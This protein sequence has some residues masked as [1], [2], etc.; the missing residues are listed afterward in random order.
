MT[1]RLRLRLA[2]VALLHGSV[3]GCSVSCGTEARLL[4]QNAAPRFEVIS[5]KSVSSAP[6]GPGPQAPDL[7][8]LPF[9]TALN[10][11]SIAYGLPVYRVIGGPSWITSDRFQVL[12]KASSSPARGQIRVLVRKLIEERFRFSG[13]LESRELPAYDLVMARSDRR[14]GPNL[15][16]APVDC[17]PYLIGERPENEGP[18]I[19]RY[20]RTVPRCALA[21]F[22]F[23]NGFMSPMLMGRT[24]QQ[25]ADY[26]RGPASRDVID[27]TG[28][29]GAFDLDLTYADERG[30]PFLS[31]LP[32]REAPALF[33]AVQEQLGLKLV[34]SK[35]TADVLVID[36][37]ERPTEN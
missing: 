27:K 22:T 34:V 29:S 35:T 10:L 8:S 17:T 24:M 5:I 36:G 20:D 28:L 3:A 23:G 31:Q 32:K 6:T 21:A 16:P 37:I 13:H 15:K 1:P 19:K 18:T 26:L 33:T 9:T 12:A 11:V 14:L 4:A 30:T 2:T 25:F 7:F